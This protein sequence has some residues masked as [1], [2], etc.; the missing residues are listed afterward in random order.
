MKSYMQFYHRSLDTSRLQVDG[1][2]CFGKVNFFFCLDEI[3][4]WN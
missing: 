1:D 3:M 4:R 2:P